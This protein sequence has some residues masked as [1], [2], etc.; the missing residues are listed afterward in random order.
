MSHESQSGHCEGLRDLPRLLAKTSLLL[1]VLGVATMSASLAQESYKKHPSSKQPQPETQTAAPSPESTAG[2][3][4]P[5]QSAAASLSEPDD[6]LGRSTPYG[7]VIGFLQSANDDDL[8]RA[9]Q[10]LDTKLPPVE[11]AELVRQL[12]VVLDTGLT[13]SLNDLSRLPQG[14]TH[15]RLRLTREQ[16]GIV[17]TSDGNLPILL[18]RINRSNEPTIWL[19]S[20]ETLAQIPDAYIHLQKHDFGK[21][22]PASL[23]RSIFGLPLW[24][25]L[26][27]CCSVIAALLLSLLLTNLLLRFIK[28]F[29]HERRIGGTKEV[30]DEL[31]VPLRLLFLSIAIW[32]LAS[33]SITLLARH[34]WSGTA[35]VLGIIGCAWFLA[36]AIGIVADALAR[37]SVAIAAREK[38]A[39]I[40]LARRLLIIL[41]IF[42]A[43]L[44]L[45]REA[46]V[47][48]TA[49]LA[50]LGIGGVALALAAQKTLEDLF[51]GISIITRETI[52]VGDYCKVADQVGIIED[53]GLSATRLRT[54]D[55][56][57]VSIPNSKIAQA[58]SENFELRDKFWFH[59]ILPFDFETTPEQLNKLITSLTGVLKATSD[60]EESGSRVNLIGFQTSTF[61]LEI[62]AYIK[63]ASYSAFLRRQQELLFRILET[64]TESGLRLA[65]PAYTT[66]VQTYPS[67]ETFDYPNALGEKPLGSRSE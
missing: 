22:L 38:L 59:H 41:A 55:R 48:V 17:R 12:K 45:L 11:A 10:Y 18:D 56:T 43:F 51:G 19:F 2:N 32:V 21:R 24:R 5:S 16:I 42:V 27:I 65:L 54:L 28:I 57:I 15:D 9:E 49:M 14:D 8:A 29:L 1:F 7:S 67:E 60:I 30:L 39:V 47:N 20:N 64:V 13:S 37:H 4:G 26:V 40:T 3:S 6:P 61:Q 66:Y 33:Y 53:I 34:Y 25:L 36:R 58:S 46:G 44:L 52:R 23:K 62:F 50:G 63:A 35:R 31:R